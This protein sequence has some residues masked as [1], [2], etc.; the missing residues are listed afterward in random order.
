M[1]TIPTDAEALGSLRAC[2]QLPI[3]GR[4][5]SMQGDHRQPQGRGQPLSIGTGIRL[6]RIEYEYVGHERSSRTEVTNSR[7]VTGKQ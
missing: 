1:L 3:F 2:V 6:Q 4:Y 7:E 5:P